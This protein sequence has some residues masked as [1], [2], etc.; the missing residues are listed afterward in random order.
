MKH[1]W[2]SPSFKLLQGIWLLSCLVLTYIYQGTIIST[3]AA[4]KMKAKYE[5]FEDVMADPRVAI[6]T[7]ENSY[8]LLC[9]SVSLRNYSYPQNIFFMLK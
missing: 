8:E 7:F 4:D 5:N 1:V 3:Y 9:L 2:K 6:G